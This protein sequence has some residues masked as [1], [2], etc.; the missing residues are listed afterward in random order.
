MAKCTNQE[1]IPSG[2][3]KYEGMLIEQLPFY[4]YELTVYLYWKGGCGIRGNRFI[5]T[6]KPLNISKSCIRKKWKDYIVEK[7]IVLLGAPAEFIND[8]KENQ[9]NG[10]VQG[11]KKSR[12]RNLR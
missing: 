10:I 2:T 8:L 7:S 5:K 12:K 1:N 6:S 4:L 11:S 9:V 3:F